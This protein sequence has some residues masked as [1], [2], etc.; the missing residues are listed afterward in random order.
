MV[1]TSLIILYIL[2]SLGILKLHLNEAMEIPINV[3]PL[4]I[5]IILQTKELG[6]MIYYIKK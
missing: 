1:Y 5:S 2:C 6:R 3:D 4:S